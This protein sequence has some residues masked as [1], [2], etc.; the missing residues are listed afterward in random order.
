MKFAAG[1]LGFSRSTRVEGAMSNL[2]RAPKF[3]V[4]YINLHR[5]ITLLL[6]RAS[7]PE[8]LHDSKLLSEPIRQQR[9][10]IC[11]VA[12]YYLP[13]AIEKILRR[14]ALSHTRKVAAGFSLI[15]QL[16]ESWTIAG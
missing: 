2:K 5:H 9:T 4:H 16:A 3:G 6:I 11:L 10:T 13:R 15:F 1:I 14:M 12:L 7:K 8:L